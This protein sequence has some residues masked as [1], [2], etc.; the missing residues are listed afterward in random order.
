MRSE[1][2]ERKIK[3]MLQFSYKLE[4]VFNDFEDKIWQ[5]SKTT[6]VDVALDKQEASSI[7]IDLGDPSKIN[8]LSSDPYLTDYLPKLLSPD[9][10]PKGVLRVGC[11]GRP[12]D[13]HPFNNFQNVVDQYEYSVPSLAALHVGS[14]NLWTGWLASKIEEHS[15]K[16]DP[17]LREMRI[18]LRKDILWEPLNVACFPEKFNLS[19]WFFLKHSVTAHDFKF[20]YD[21]VMNPYVS[22]T[23]A[24][25]LRATYS[26]IAEF[27]VI[28]D[29][30]FSIFWR[31][32]E[33]KNNQGKTEFNLSA[34]LYDALYA[35]KPL[36]VF[37]YQ[38][39][40]NGDKI[41]E[42][43]EEVNYQLHSEW[44]RNFMS[45]WAGNY[46]V[47]CGPLV[48]S[49]ILDDRIC[50]ERNQ[51]TTFPYACLYEKKIIFIKE[52]LEA[53]LQ[54]FKNSKIDLCLEPATHTAQMEEFF[55]SSEYAGQEA[56]GE[57]IETIYA[58]EH[59]YYYVGWNCNSKF[60]NDKKVRQALAMA[61]DKQRLIEQQLNSTAI[62][63]TGPF[64]H[65]S[66]E[67]DKSVKDWPFS[68]EEARAIL[69]QQGWRDTEGTGI[70]EKIIDGKRVPFRF[71]LCYFAKSHFMKN[72]CEHIALSL[73]EIGIDCRLFGLDLADFSFA[74][75]E[76]SF[77][78][79]MTSWKIGNM[80]QNPKPFWHSDFAEEKG[81][82]NGVSFQNPDVDLWI[83]QL[84]YEKNLIHREGIYHKI[85]QKLHEE[86]PYLFL[87]TRKKKLLHRKFIKNIFVPADNKHIIPKASDEDL[88]MRSLWITE[89]K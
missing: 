36:P 87:F 25:I 27:K 47:S 39:F 9:F 37:V 19:P 74:W 3:G 1:H 10:V 42:D 41:V 70:R 11:V 80:F 78:A 88:Y 45:H 38:Y 60:F 75:Q 63:V 55:K 72:L 20:A 6:V 51:N 32:H 18:Y 57:G 15:V 71:K 34:S 52:N 4:R 17:S 50:F 65:G 54:D 30:T 7:E 76:K 43:D 59:S 31:A 8:L 83:D 13:L 73:K 61:I 79:I 85:H 56:K 89:N 67:Y 44:A 24:T 40:A 82:L 68:P 53:L 81:S 48:F 86:S 62:S 35:M 2:L 12:N 29:F 33:V 16:H 26:D 49:G 69:D 22:K 14:K 66:L 58:K 23:K 5:N 46:I 28:D 21:A 77:D 64:A 84:L